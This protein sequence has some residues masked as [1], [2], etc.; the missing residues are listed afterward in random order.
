ME[1]QVTKHAEKR[2]RQ[3]GFSRFSI[4]ILEQFGR[5][6]DAPGKAKKI[7]FGNKEHQLAISEFKKAIQFLDKAKGGTMIIVN[8]DILTVYK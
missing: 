4:E 1:L 7:F 5:L 8:D 3:R 2:M 6:E